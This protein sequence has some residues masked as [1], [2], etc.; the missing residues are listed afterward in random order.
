MFLDMR[1]RRKEKKIK[2]INC[3]SFMRVVVKKDHLLLRY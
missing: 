2:R 1:E 3:F